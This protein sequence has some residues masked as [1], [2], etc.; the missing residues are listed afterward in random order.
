MFF[1]RGIGDPNQSL[2]AGYHEGVPSQLADALS[3]S[4]Q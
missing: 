3:F 4:D 2:F 1:M